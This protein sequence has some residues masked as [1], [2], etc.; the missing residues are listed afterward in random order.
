MNQRKNRKFGRKMRKLNSKG[1]DEVYSNASDLKSNDFFMIT[2]VVNLG[3]L[4]TEKLWPAKSLSYKGILRKCGHFIDTLNSI[5]TELDNNN[6]KLTQ[7]IFADQL[8]R[9]DGETFS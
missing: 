7:E 3:I 4:S 5:F 2:H 6:N 1:V 8:N 9:L